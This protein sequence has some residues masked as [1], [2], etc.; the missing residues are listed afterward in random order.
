VECVEIFGNPFDT[1]FG[2]GKLNYKSSI[3][4]KI[5]SKHKFDDGVAPLNTF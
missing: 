3:N 5:K 2:E 1:F 4:V